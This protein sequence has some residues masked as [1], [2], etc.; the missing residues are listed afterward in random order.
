MIFS[1]TDILGPGHNID[2][3]LGLSQLQI[4]FCDKSEFP[5]IYLN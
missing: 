1:H 3:D 4:C 5:V 2:P